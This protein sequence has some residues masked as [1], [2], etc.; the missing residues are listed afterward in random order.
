MPTRLRCRCNVRAGSWE[1][2]RSA[3]HRIVTHGGFRSR[4]AQVVRVTDV[5][6]HPGDDRRPEPGS[7]WAPLRLE[8]RDIDSG[9]IGLPQLLA[10]GQELF[11]LDFGPGFL[12]GL[13]DNSC[14]CS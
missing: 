6:Q 1:R 13:S 10:T 4:V 14:A 9:R 5:G 2:I 7:Q 11:V 3:I 12:K 8:Q